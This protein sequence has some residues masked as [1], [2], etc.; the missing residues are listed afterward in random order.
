VANRYQKS[1]TCFKMVR[2]DISYLYAGSIKNSYLPKI[3]P[4]ILKT[5]GV[6]VDLRCYPSDFLVYTFANDLLP[7][8]KEF[9]KFS[10]A[11][12]GEPGLFK[13]LPPVKTGK[14]N[15]D[16]FKGKVV[17]LINENTQSSAED[18][19]A[20]RTAPKVK[21]IGSTT[22]AADGDVSAIFLPGNIGTY[23]SGLG[24]YYPDGKGTQ[25]VGIVQDIEVKPTIKGISEGRD[26]L[27]EKAIEIID[28]N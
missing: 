13:F 2:A 12:I 22:A 3:V 24:V 1:D 27:V 19:M 16:Y 20:F 17:I 9:V 23:V 6:I 21:V 26:E 14:V 15:G 18:T 11:S 28:E 25:R 7:G 5:K 8:P 10:A 4:E